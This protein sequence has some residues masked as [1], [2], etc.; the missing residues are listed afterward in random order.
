MISSD[1]KIKIILKVWDDS[2]TSQD[3]VNELFW[4]PDL[5]LLMRSISENLI[6]LKQDNFNLHSDLKILLLELHYLV[7]EKANKALVDEKFPNLVSNLRKLYWFDGK[8]LEFKRNDKDYSSK[9]GSSYIQQND[10]SPKII[11]SRL[12]RY[13]GKLKKVM[14]ANSIIEALLQIDIDEDQIKQYTK[15]FLQSLLFD[16]KQNRSTLQKRLNKSLIKEAFN[17][18]EVEIKGNL[19]G[20]SEKI[21]KEASQFIVS[22]INEITADSSLDFKDFIEQ[23]KSGQSTQ[24]KDYAYNIYGF[25][26]NLTKYSDS[27]DAKDG[28]SE[29]E[30]ELFFRILLYSHLSKDYHKHDPLDDQKDRDVA[31]KDLLDSVYRAVM[32]RVNFLKDYSEVIDPS[33]LPKSIIANFKEPITQEYIARKS[34]HTKFRNDLWYKVIISFTK[35]LSKEISIGE[36]QLESPEIIKKVKASQKVFASITLTEFSLLNELLEAINKDFSTLLTK[37]REGNLIDTSKVVVFTEITDHIFASLSTGHYDSF[38][39]NIDFDQFTDQEY[40][41]IL[42]NSLEAQIPKIQQYQV[43]TA[44]SHIDLEGESKKI[45]ENTYL[46]DARKW[47]S[48]ENN[49][50]DF[51]KPSNFR[52]PH[53]EY[54]DIKYASP[55]YFMASH[56]GWGQSINPNGKMVRHATRIVSVEEA[57]GVD[58]AIYKTSI[59]ANKLKRLLITPW[60][61]YTNTRQSANIKISNQFFVVNEDFTDYNF[62]DLNHSE[63]HDED[64]LTLKSE[65]YKNFDSIYLPLLTRNN[66]VDQGILES[67]NYWQEAL[68][69]KVPEKQFFILIKALSSILSIDPTSTAKGGE[70]VYLDILASTSNSQYWKKFLHHDVVSLWKEINKDVDMKKAYKKI[71][72]KSSYYLDLLKSIDAI[73]DNSAFLKL[74][75]NLDAFYS[76]YKRSDLIGSTRY[77]RSMAELE[78]VI[79]KTKRHS[80]LHHDNVNAYDAFDTPQYNWKL[81]KIYREL[82]VEVLQSRNNGSKTYD[83][84]VA[85]LNL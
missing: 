49:Q 40:V 63:I 6:R 29:N 16:Y 27:D 48:G 55:F 77:L 59:K 3:K 18:I 82:F 28:F 38:I 61:Y 42:K 1:E 58:E 32:L 80:V 72:G 30:I 60:T 70:K 84:I 62:K 52:G 31:Y 66:E 26:N 78:L 35:G 47:D 79:W 53:Q 65:P 69:E 68:W 81:E 14:D 20:Q 76:N 51:F 15:Y 21:S 22:T 85:N 83:D 7:R 67:I 75:S 10:Y 56:T 33:K 36:L 43:I 13:M 46:Y 71:V 5:F 8:K 41:R 74:K 73:K 37:L 39:R 19:T 24:Q 11:F 64:K 44:L 45:D 54:A 23:I 50:L 2:L 25:V 17:T 57:Y 4:E 34:L 12:E 9:R